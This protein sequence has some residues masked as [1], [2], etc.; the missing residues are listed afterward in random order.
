MRNTEIKIIIKQN[1]RSRHCILM[2]PPSKA[3]Q[4]HTF[5]VWSDLVQLC[6]NT[7]QWH[8]SLLMYNYF[9]FEVQRPADCLIYLCCVIALKC[10]FTYADFGAPLY[11]KLRFV[12]GQ[13]AM[14]K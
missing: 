5:Q 13:F 1:S 8:D 2:V 9:T 3:T 6:S 10:L 7:W 14:S 12:G 11:K 4:V